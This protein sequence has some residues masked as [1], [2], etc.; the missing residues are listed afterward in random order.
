MFVPP[1]NKL[2]QQIRTKGHD[3]ATLNMLLGFYGEGEEIKHFKSVEV[4]KY[5][6]ICFD[7]IMINPPKILKKIDL[8]MMQHPDK[9]YF[10]TGDVNQLQ[11][12][13]WTPN[14]VKD[15]RE[16][17]SSCIRRLFP[18][19]FTLKINKRLKTQE[20]KD[21]LAQLYLDVFDTK[22]DI[23]ETLKHHG[24]KI[25]TE[26][27]QVKTLSNICY[28]NYRT[29]EVNK[30]VH[31]KL[32][33]KPS[34]AIKIKGVEYWKEL[35]LTCKK[36]HKEKGKK[37]FVNY[38]YNLSS[39]SDKVFTV[40]DPVEG[41]SMTLPTAKLNHFSLPYANTC[42]SVQGMSIDVPMTIFDVNTP[43]VD[44]YFVWTALTRATDFNNVTIFQHSK[45]EVTDLHIS[46][47]K[48]YFQHKSDNY[49]RQDKTAGR[50][51]NTS[52]EYVNADWFNDEYCKLPIKSCSAC[53]S[54]YEIHIDANGEVHTNLTAD[55][56]N[57]KLT[58]VQS[59]IRLL[60]N[61]CN[62]TRGNKY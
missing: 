30:Y 60:C 50:L 37:L 22:K 42:H 55:R 25:I 36:H 40:V 10:A 46:R 35:N 47:V 59:N 57:N 56:I 20:Q 48:Q 31:S 44:R 5:D 2:A 49:K 33:K 62:C 7:E 54:P 6:C 24:F 27:S 8:Y 34:S 39:I 28:F 4:S 14:N 1:Y 15:K 32:V 17:L 41:T 16:Y 21:K 18:N 58:H 52:D 61:H 11:P 13:N 9:K 3:A 26:F 45:K 43:Y 38:S 19:K 53:L 51:W 12:I 23:M 29:N